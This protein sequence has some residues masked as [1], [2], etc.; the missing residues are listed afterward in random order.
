[1][2]SVCVTCTSNVDGDG[3]LLLNPVETAMRGFPKVYRNAMPDQFGEKPSFTKTPFSI[4]WTLSIAVAA[5]VY[6]QR[7]GR[8][9]LRRAGEFQL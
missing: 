9:L 3:C 2:Y 7:P 6:P 4:I 5:H 8:A 1:M